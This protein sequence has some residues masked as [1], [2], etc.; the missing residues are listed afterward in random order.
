MTLP[1]GYVSLRRFAEVRDVNLSAVQ[2]AIES[3][4][5]TSVLREGD[6]LVGIH[7]VQAMVEWDANTDPVEAARNGKLP[8]AEPAAGG[9]EAAPAATPEPAQP[10]SN[11]AYLDARARR[12]ELRGEERGARLPEKS[13]C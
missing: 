5:V 7:Q 10:S 12:E 13:G 6:R 4:R 3:G 11:Q 1:D 2:K 9:T 8:L